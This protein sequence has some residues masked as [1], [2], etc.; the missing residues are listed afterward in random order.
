MKEQEIINYFKSQGFN[1]MKYGKFPELIVWG[2]LIG[3][4]GI[5]IQIPTFFKSG[6]G[7]NIIPFLVMGVTYKKP[8]KKN[9]EKIELLLGKLFSSLAII[10]KV[11]GGM[12]I[13]IMSKEVIKDG[14]SS[15]YIG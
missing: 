8:T 5:P 13:D 3:S 2:P 11:K 12:K 10:K 1:C 6:K 14:R 9:I 15:G 7:E 4:D